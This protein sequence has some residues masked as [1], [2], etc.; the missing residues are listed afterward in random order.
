LMSHYRSTLDFSDTALQAAEKGFKK[1][2]TSWQRLNESLKTAP[3]KATANLLPIS[4]FQEEFESAMNDDFNT[5]Q[6]IAAMFE[7]FNVANKQL[8]SKDTFPTKSE[9]ESALD[10]LK[11][12]AGQVLGLLD[13]D[14]ESNTSVDKMDGV[15][16]LVLDL[17]AELR[18]EKNFA[19]SDKI[20]DTLK[21][22]GIMVKDTPDGSS[23]GL[24]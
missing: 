15:M 21:E 24:E 23:W 16:Q 17:R 7:F 3:K 13:Q 5:P 20:R 6:A 2:Q 8:D 4:E 9:L 19:M 11:K 18:K 12:T 22:I 14:N 1:L 10:V